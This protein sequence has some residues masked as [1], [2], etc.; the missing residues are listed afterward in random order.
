MNGKQNVG[1]GWCADGGRSTKF[2]LAQ[3]GHVA[4]RTP[5]NARLAPQWLQENVVLAARSDATPVIAARIIADT[6]PDIR[7]QN[8][9][10]TSR[11]GDD[12]FSNNWPALAR[13]PFKGSTDML[14]VIGNVIAGGF[15]LGLF[16]ATLRLT[17]STK[18]A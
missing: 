1:S 2:G 16:T 11:A 14:A 6:S 10:Y 8:L 5:S 7:A 17:K 4:V 3:Y 9:V 15:A 18:R 12:F 13:C